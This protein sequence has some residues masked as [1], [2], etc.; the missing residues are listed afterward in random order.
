[1]VTLNNSHSSREDGSA[2]TINL[3][4]QTWA[5]DYLTKL[6]K[7]IAD[8]TEI[9]FTKKEFTMKVISPYLGVVNWMKN[10]INQS[11]KDPRFVAASVNVVQGTANSLILR[12]APNN[13]LTD[14]SGNMQ[15]DLVA[16]TRFR[17]GY[18]YVVTQESLQKETY[19]F[20]NDSQLLSTY[21]TRCVTENHTFFKKQGWVVSAEAVDSRPY[22]NCLKIGHQKDSC[23]NEEMCQN[24]FE[25]GYHKSV[26][27]YYVHRQDVPL[28]LM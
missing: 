21:R 5:I 7:A 3:A 26:C 16:G 11:F 10:Q 6:R 20:D 2:S 18:F 9:G 25:P 12:L 8:E 23:P 13:K 4:M 22:R 24:C 28:S 27:T 17:Y 19:G 1:M 15:D 14:F